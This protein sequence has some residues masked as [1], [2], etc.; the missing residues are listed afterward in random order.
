VFDKKVILFGSEGNVKI[1]SS[2]FIAD[3]DDDQLEPSHNAPKC[4]VQAVEPVALSARLVDESRCCEQ[5]CRLPRCVARRLGG[6]IADPQDCDKAVRVTLGLFI[7]VQ[8][9]RGV[10]IL[11]PVID[12]C[13]PEKECEST[14]DNPCEAFRRIGFPLDEFFPPRE[15]ELTCPETLKDLRHM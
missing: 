5:I 14:T 9:V 13:V 4:I 8:L 15:G 10:S 1:F 2:E 3:A 6:D 12:F 7:I 11:I